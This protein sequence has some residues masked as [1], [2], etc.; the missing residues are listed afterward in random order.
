MKKVL[1]IIVMLL[2]IPFCNITKVEAQT[3]VYN[4]TDF[5]SK[6]INED[7]EWGD[8]S[9]WEESDMIITMDLNKNVV[10][11]HSPT[12]QTYHITEFVGKYTDEYGGEQEEYKFYDQDYDKGTM[13][14]RV[15]ENGNSQLYIEFANIMWVYNVKQI[16]IEEDE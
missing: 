12:P 13:R 3:Y 6:E 5:A 4:T 8:W 1:G 10:K 14:L 15:E 11:V 16:N 2:F 9:D 7:G